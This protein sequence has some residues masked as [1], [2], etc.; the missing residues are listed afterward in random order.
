MAELKEKL[1][2][3][4]D[5]G[6][7][8]EQLQ[9]K[10][11]KV[12]E[13][14]AGEQI[15]A[16][17]DLREQKAKYEK[18]IAELKAQRMTPSEERALRDKLDTA[19][20]MI[21]VL[22]SDAT[23]KL[24]QQQKY[25]QDMI[26]RNRNLKKQTETN[27]KVQKAAVKAV[28][29][30]DNLIR[31]ETDYAH[32]PE[33]L[34]PVV[35]ELL[36]MMA[37]NDALGAPLVWDKDKAS[38]L[39][40][41]FSRRLL[42]TGVY[43]GSD[44]MLTDALSEAR[45]ALQLLRSARTTTA[46]RTGENLLQ[47]RARERGAALESL[48]DAVT[49][50]YN[51]VQNENS[52]QIAG[53][54][55]AVADLGDEALRGLNARDDAKVL[56][57]KLGKAIKSLDKLLRTGNMTPVYFFKNIGND[58][59]TKLNNEIREGSNRYG[60]RVAEAQRRFREIGA[61]YNAA[62]W[63]MNKALN[64]ETESGNVTLTLGQA[65]TLAATWK[66]EHSNVDLLSKHLEVG[67]FILQEQAAKN[68]QWQT[69]GHRM[70]DNDYNKLLS[71]MTTD[72]LN[73]V[74]D[75]VGFMSKDLSEWGNETSMD[76]YGIKLFKEGYYIP[77]VTDPNARYH[78]SNAGANAAN[79][80]RIKHPGFSNRRISG[81]N[82]TIIIDDFQTVVARHAQDMINY[83]TMAIPVENL[84]K[85]L[86]YKAQN[87]SAED[88]GIQPRVSQVFRQKYGDTALGYLQDYMKD[89]NGGVQTDNRGA[90][91]KWLS[92]FKKGKVVGSLSVAAKQPLSYI[93][94]A[95][96]MDPKY[97]I[98]AMG[99]VG[100]SSGTYDELMKYS[101]V[102][103]LKQMG[104]FDMGIGTGAADYIMQPVDEFSLWQKAKQAMNPK[105]FDRL[106]Q[107]WS[108][109]VTYL[110][111][112]MDEVTWVKMWKAV[113]LE[114]AEAM[115]HIDHNS[116]SF[117]EACGRRFNEIMDLTQVYDSTLTKSN[118][119]RS[120]NSL[121]KMSTAFMAEPTLTANMLYDAVMNAKEPGGAKKAATAA[122]VFT[123]SA[124]A[125]SVVTSFFSSIRAKGAGDDDDTVA[126]RMSSSLLE[127]ILD[128]MNPLTNVPFVKDILEVMSG[129]DIERTDYSVISDLVDA[130]SYVSKIDLS[131]P[132]SIA[133]S[134]QKIAGPIAQLFGIPL[135]NVT[136]DV[137]A[138]VNL[139]KLSA[140]QAAGS[141]STDWENVGYNLASDLPGYDS[142]TTA[143]YER[144][145][146]ALADG[147]AEADQLMEYMTDALGKSADAITT[148]TRSAIRTMI[149]NGDLTLE[150]AV[151]LSVK[152][153]LYESEKKAYSGL[154]K[155]ASEDGNGTV[156]TPVYD[157]I[158]G[159]SQEDIHGAIDTM[160]QYDY[161]ASSISSQL[162]T[163][164]KPIIAQKYAAGEPIADLVS[165]ILDAY[166]YL[167]YDREKSLTKIKSW[168]SE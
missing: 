13:Q 77:F 75:M 164:Y 80:T 45:M 128:N 142:S 46:T 50:I 9:E 129:D 114:M 155:A 57:S 139:V 78:K 154:A 127:N 31:N 42:E 32:V 48:R 25:Y 5:S 22:Q 17:R 30:L 159:G 102:A 160:L 6:K 38:T 123:V 90:M 23:K 83:S 116:D 59:L 149:T 56:D 161:T 138:M 112:K 98:R 15:G 136:R 94:A 51:T 141:I 55:Q 54:R 153:G 86:N 73:Y 1:S 70:T 20:T 101:G 19:Q 4:K 40:G 120:Q 122:A 96:V 27:A 12:N 66:R 65:M 68:K 137:R 147:S 124:L 11:W 18:Q 92:L 71:L 84:S 104:G 167:G 100:S 95:A 10:L 91:D 79:D 74:D 81:A 2:Q 52:V 29:K 28:K 93:R 109:A 21:Q 168:Y 113:K 140:R 144:Y 37:D 105:D 34:K 60:L 49:V 106:K 115:P 162:T 163:Y 117:L 26:K 87:G 16:A 146:S 7:R 8:I 53:K 157:A 107:R 143:W 156:Y 148:G 151:D 108:E 99:Q 39:T 165:Y 132:D 166:E 72:Q 61:K 152:A 41:F 3:A 69:M 43:T 110:P 133:Y 62:S 88:I 134:V 35:N 14:L 85:V 158:E 44:T 131:T 64:F 111:G 125:E 130:Y 97:L 76:L 33:E 89:L 118:N 126:E 47:A 36:G 67:G 103:V 58:V 24:M 63:D 150:E 119:M 145:A 82:N 135:T 121:A